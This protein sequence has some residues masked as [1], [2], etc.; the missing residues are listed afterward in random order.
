MG[1]VSNIIHQLKTIATTQK[2]V[3]TTRLLPI[4]IAI[5]KINAEQNKKI[6]QQKK[7]I[8]DMNKRYQRAKTKADKR[9]KRLEELEEYYGRSTKS[10]NSKI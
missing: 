7:A 9:L 3:R 5:G 10:G 1:S 6:A 4:I 8:D 2:T